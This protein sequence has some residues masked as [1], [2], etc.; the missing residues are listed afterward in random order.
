MITDDDKFWKTALS[1][2]Q[3]AIKLKKAMQ[4]KGLRKAK[5]KC[6]QCEGYLYGTLNGHKDHIHIR[7]TGSCKRQ[8]ME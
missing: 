2:M 7:C 4:K 1:T 3:D 5:A 6:P 8:M